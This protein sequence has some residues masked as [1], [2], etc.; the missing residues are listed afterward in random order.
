[1]LSRENQVFL[2]VVR[3]WQI[4]RVLQNTTPRQ[5]S[6]CWTGHRVLSMVLTITSRKLSLNFMSIAVWQEM[7]DKV[8]VGTLTNNT[9]SFRGFGLSISGEGKVL[10]LFLLF[11]YPHC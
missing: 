11:T 1:M 9:H 6:P 10:F 3:D 2:F 5:T 7:G 8:A 4:D